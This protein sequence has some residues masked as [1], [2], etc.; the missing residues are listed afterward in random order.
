MATE[1]FPNAVT[2][3]VPAVWYR[4][5]LY[6]MLVLLFNGTHHQYV[7]KNNEGNVIASWNCLQFL[8]KCE[9]KAIL[10]W[11]KLK[12]MWCNVLTT[13]RHFPPTTSI[14]IIIWRVHV[15][16]KDTITVNDQSWIHRIIIGSKYKKYQVFASPRCYNRIIQYYHVF[17]LCFKSNLKYEQ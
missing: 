17:F 10:I 4:A 13:V 11:P 15:E 16:N 8:M 14:A 7:K 9:I 3:P 1:V 5:N 12:G 6:N 2:Y